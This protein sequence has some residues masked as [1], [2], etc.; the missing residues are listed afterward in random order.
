MTRPAA[1]APT[2][3][4]HFKLNLQETIDI[5]SL[6]IPKPVMLSMESIQKKGKSRLYESKKNILSA[7]E[8]TSK[9]SSRGSANELPSIQTARPHSIEGRPCSPAL[10]DMSSNTATNSAT[11]SNPN[12][13]GEA[14]TSTV[15]KVNED[16]MTLSDPNTV[17]VKTE[18]LQGGCLAGDHLPMRISIRH[19]KVVKS[20]QGIII[21]LYRQGRIDT[22]PAIPLGPFRKGEKRRY[23]DYYPRSRTGL[24][25]LSLSSAGSSRSFRQDL[26]QVVVPII[27]DPQS[28]TTVINTSIEAPPHLFPSITDV[29]GAMVNFIYYVEIVIDLRG[30]LSGQDRIR[31]HLSL[32]SGPQHGYG[33]PKLSRWEGSDGINYHS[34]PAFNYLIT[35]QLRRTR[36]IIYTKTEVI[37]GTKDSTRKRGKQA[38]DRFKQLEPI[39]LQDSVE[40]GREEDVRFVNSNGDS[41]EGDRETPIERPHL[42]FDSNRQPDSTQVPESEEPIDEKEQ[43]RRA[44]QRLLPSAPPQDDDQPPSTAPMPSAPFAVDEEDFVHRYALEAPAPAY[45]GPSATSVERESRRDH[46]HRYPTASSDDKQELERRRLLDLASSPTADTDEPEVA[47]TI[48][49]AL[50]PSAPILYEDDIFSVD[51]PRIPESSPADFTH[52]RITTQQLPNSQTRSASSV[53][54]SPSHSSSDLYRQASMNGQAVHDDNDTHETLPTNSSEMDNEDLPEYRK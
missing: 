49:G 13:T 48:M 27:I 45:D 16:V 33:D 39:A 28:L 5:A 9:C 15:R 41:H 31:P 17:S 25:G 3:V 24:G 40:L 4:Q 19:N 20:M 21:T 44:E 53:G 10:S 42:G 54:Q 36:G 18:I 51:D 8:R 47:S 6:Q 12:C 52:D 2:S 34:S 23:E 29:P 46:L 26:A 11:S 50:E 32:T 38:E 14:L 43:V 22:H 37:I 35:D 30:K 7:S 1:I